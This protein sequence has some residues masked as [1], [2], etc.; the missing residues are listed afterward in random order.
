VAADAALL[1]G[2]KQRPDAEGGQD[3]V[4][5]K[6]HEV[7]RLTRRVVLRPG[8]EGAR[9]VVQRREQEDRGGVGR[10]GLCVV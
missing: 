3:G 7:R 9:A 6:P 8:V 4:S 1:A 2:E 10:E 5:S